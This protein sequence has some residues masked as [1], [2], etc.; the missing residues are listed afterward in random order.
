MVT[1]SEVIVWLSLGLLVIA[2]SRN[3][4]EAYNHHRS[5]SAIRCDHPIFDFGTVLSGEKRAHTFHIK[6]VGSLPLQI[7]GV[8]A[9][10]GCTTV[11][12][13][14]VGRIIKVN[15][16]LAI[17]V[18]L[19]LSNLP[20]GEVEKR[21]VLLF[22]GDPGRQ[23][24]LTLKGVVTPRWTSSPR[25]VG[26]LDLAPDQVTSR[27][28]IVQLNPDAPWMD[29]KHVSSPNF[30]KA[31]IEPESM[32]NEERIWKVR[33]TTKPPLPL[34]KRVGTILLQSTNG[35]PE[36]EIVIPVELEVVADTP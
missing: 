3:L 24:S 30:L 11:E 31:H 16:S 15:E 8:H 27:D 28:I 1:V 34:G 19:S 7:E 18:E 29:I 4:W 13:E 33:V 9:A 32:V 36:G 23:L 21:I 14:L 17:P 10:C 35:S 2:I 6:N 26:F 20:P 12:G 25:T 22:S 5:Y